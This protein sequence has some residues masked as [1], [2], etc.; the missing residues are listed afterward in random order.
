MLHRTL[1]TLERNGPAAV[2][3]R[4][5]AADAESS[6][7]AV[8]ELFGDKHGVIRSLFLDGFHRLAQLLHELSSVG[9][10]RGDLIASLD[11]TRAFA[12]E[13]PALFEVMYQRPF[14]EFQ[15]GPSDLEAAQSIYVHV[16]GRVATWIGAP[17]RAARTIDAAHALVALNRGLV[18]DE[19][20]GVLGNTPA[21]I[22]RRRRVAI[23]AL[24]DGLDNTN[25][26]RR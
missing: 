8:Y 7:A 17:K 14:I 25:N 22:G 2:T 5:I 10:G 6:T 21:S 20:A 11:T 13:S 4:R 26:A 3:A 23:N 1:L 15:P 18:A 19:I 9:D 24:L 12:V 16:V